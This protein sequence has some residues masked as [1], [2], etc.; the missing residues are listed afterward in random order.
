MLILPRT[1]PLEKVK[2]RTEGLSLF[3]TALD[4]KYV[5]VREIAK[6]GRSAVNCNELF[7]EALPFRRPTASAMRA[8]GFEYILHGMNAERILIGAEAVGLGH[9]ALRKAAAYKGSE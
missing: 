1:T 7:I 9:A 4:R 3:Y 8:R 5:D 6:M 2:R